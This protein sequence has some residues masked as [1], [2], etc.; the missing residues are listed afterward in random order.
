MRKTG[1]QSPPRP[2]Q[3]GAKAAPGRPHPTGTE[4]GPVSA[5]GQA[6]GLFRGEPENRVGRLTQ[7]QDETI[8]SVAA[9]VSG[10]G[11]RKWRKT[12]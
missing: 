2:A 4:P 1:T 10:S 8:T 3:T 11:W 12:G 7:M 9:R 6:D 5:R